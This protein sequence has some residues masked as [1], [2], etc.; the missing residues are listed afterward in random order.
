VSD[1]TL[2]AV[3][4][5]NMEINALCEAETCRHLFTFDLEALIDA[6]G[7]DYKL[8]DIP[9]LSCP[10]CGTSSLTIRLSF[11]DPPQGTE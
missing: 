6:A 2:G 1:W 8:A 3:K 9:P 5:H 11:A 4:A 7:S 10:N